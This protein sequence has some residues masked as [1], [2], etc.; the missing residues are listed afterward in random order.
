MARFQDISLAFDDII[1][2]P[3]SRRRKVELSLIHI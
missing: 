2:T 3:L 1:E